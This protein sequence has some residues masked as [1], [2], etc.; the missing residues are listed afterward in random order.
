MKRLTKSLFFDKTQKKT[1]KHIQQKSPLMLSKRFFTSNFFKIN[2]PKLQIKVEPRDLMKRTDKRAEQYLQIFK[3]VRSITSDKKELGLICEWLNTIFNKQMKNIS[4]ELFGRF[5]LKMIREEDNRERVLSELETFKRNI[6]MFVS[7]II[8]EYFLQFRDD[9]QDFDWSAS[10]SSS[11]G[12]SGKIKRS[13]LPSQL[14]KK[15]KKIRI[16]KKTEGRGLRSKSNL[17]AKSQTFG[18]PAKRLLG[19]IA[20]SK[21]SDCNKSKNVFKERSFRYLELD[22]SDE[23]KQKLKK[24]QMLTKNSNSLQ[25]KKLNLS[26]IKMKTGMEE[27]EIF[28]SMNEFNFETMNETFSKEPNKKRVTKDSKKN[29][30]KKPEPR[31]VK[32]QLKQ[33][34]FRISKKQY[35]ISGIS[36]KFELNTFRKGRKAKP[37]AKHLQPTISK[38]IRQPKKKEQI[39]INLNIFNN[40]NHESDSGRNLNPPFPEYPQ[41]RQMDDFLNNLKNLKVK[42]DPTMKE[43]IYTYEQTDTHKSKH[44]PESFDQLNADFNR[45]NQKWRGLKADIYASSTYQMERRNWEREA[46]RANP[47]F[48]GSEAENED[49]AFLKKEDKKPRKSNTK[50]LRDLAERNKKNFLHIMKNPHYGTKP[51][52]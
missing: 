35:S 17:L 40:N 29:R 44:F 27:S 9:F 48:S 5:R 18:E 50:N 1:S 20:H 34:T 45:S 49:E 47:S 38:K 7:V 25:F 36:K 15:K 21:S 6:L 42:T 4:Q 26:P 3:G 10:S 51:M 43:S 8:D 31:P 16:R 37:K 2:K 24:L 23:R 33:K 14:Q 19:R 39:Q 46:E 41:P 13:P 12:R 22:N 52:H 28:K 32:R 11:V 30:K